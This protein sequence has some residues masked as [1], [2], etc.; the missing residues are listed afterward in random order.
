MTL[1]FPG[2]SVL[3]AHHNHLGAL[4]AQDSLTLIGSI[5]ASGSG[6]WASERF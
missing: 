1:A 3:A 2:F 6:A 4:N 5:G